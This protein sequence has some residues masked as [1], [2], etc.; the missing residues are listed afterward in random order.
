MKK[1]VFTKPFGD[2]TK[3]EVG[4]YDGMLASHLVRV[5]KVAKYYKEKSTII[6]K[7]KK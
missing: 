5:K 7:L 4:E 3:G 6:G 1:V 2:K